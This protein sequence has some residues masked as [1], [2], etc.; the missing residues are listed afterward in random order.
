ME[1]F[2]MSRQTSDEIDRFLNGAATFADM[3]WGFLDESSEPSQRNLQDFVDKDGDHDD[4]DLSPRHVEEN[5]IFWETQEQ[6]LQATLFRT[7]SLETRIRQATK[8]AI[9][10]LN[11]A[12]VLCVCR[13][14]AAGNCRKCLQR[15]L[16][17]R[18]QNAG[19]NCSLCKSKWKSTPEIPSGEHKYLE[20]VEKS[21]KGEVRVVIE[22]NFRAEFEMARAS[23]EYNRLISG[24]PELFVGKAERLKA[25]IKILCAAAKKCMKDK[26]MHLAPWRKH[27][28]M[29]AKW[30]GTYEITAPAPLPED[31]VNRV[32]KPKTSMLT[33]DL[34]SNLPGIHCT[35]V[36][37]V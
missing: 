24:I 19:F 25:L 18:L 21:K 34:R 2:Q 3:L 7:T 35:A 10:E 4:E 15:E 13:R 11:L 36:E 16:S 28:Y 22:L 33:F 30:L 31:R 26:K 8:E 29:Q 5:R 23:E 20:V 9:K 6:L 14:P 27:K 1:N 17:I 32:P 12:G 37:V